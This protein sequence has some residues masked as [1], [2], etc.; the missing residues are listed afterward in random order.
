MRSRRARLA[1]R[2]LDPWSVFVMSLLLSL[3]LAVV[4]LVAAVVLYAILSKLGIPKSIN[5][6]VSDVEGGGEVLTKGRF[7]G[8]AAL[9]AAINVVLLT[10]FATLGSLLYNVCAT[11]TGGLE[12]TLAERD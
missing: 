8:W 10:A 3:F 1:L 6:A 12:V 11:F 2:R 5:K 7:L 9:L 4:T